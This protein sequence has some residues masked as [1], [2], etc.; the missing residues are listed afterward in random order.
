MQDDLQPLDETPYKGRNL[1]YAGTFTNPF[2]ANVI[3]VVEW[4]TGKLTLLKLVRKFE[5]AGQV[6][7]TDFWRRA[8]VLLQIDLKTPAEQIANIP[9]TGPVVIVANHPHGLVDGMILADLVSRVRQDYK[10]LT[11]SLLT[12]VPIIQYHMLPVAF[13]HEPD[14]IKMNIAMR[15]LA[16]EHLKDNGVI[17]LFPAGQ[18]A[19]SPDWFGPALEADWL[20]FTAKMILKSKAKVVPVYFPGQNSRWFQIANKLSITIR[21][22]LLLHEI[23]Y[24]MNRPQKP[25]IGPVIDRDQIDPWVDDPRGFMAHLKKTALAL[26]E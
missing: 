12:N 16:M 8:I 25:V 9:A 21:Q 19:T 10:I 1:S 24:A 11:R 5:A 15:K 3:R 20:P 22:G 17:I 2:K 14:A 7:S 23:A 13:P 6:K 4:L 26:K 18:V